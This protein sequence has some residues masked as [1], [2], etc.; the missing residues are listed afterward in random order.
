[1]T[2]IVVL[3]VALLLALPL[4][5]FGA[6]GDP[7]VGRWTPLG[8]WGATIF[9]LA[10]DPADPDRFY[11]GTPRGLFVSTDQMA[12]WHLLGSLPGRPTVGAIFVDPS[13]P[14]RI[15]AAVNATLLGSTDRGATWTSSSIDQPI[16]SLLPEVNCLVGDPTHPA[17]L[18]ACSG[19][20]F[21]QGILKSTDGGS[22]FSTVSPD[23]D[24]ANVAAIVVDPASPSTLYAAVPGNREPAL[25][26]PIGVVKSLDGGATWQARNAGLPGTAV[27][28]VVR[29]PQ[30]GALYA[31]LSSG[32]VF[33]SLDGAA[34][35]AALPVA[36]PPAS[37]LAAAPDG[38]LYLGGARGIFRSANGGATWTATPERAAAT[39]L[40]VGLGGP[41]AAAVYA[42][43]SGG[44][45]RSADSGRTWP[46]SKTGLTELAS[47]PL[48]VD[49]QTSELWITADHTYRSPGGGSAFHRLG[50]DVRS[51]AIDPTDSTRLYGILP[52]GRLVRSLD[53]G[54][55]WD[56]LP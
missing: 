10:A 17:I 14:A 7:P 42:A 30:T 56:V 34:G 22:H 16:P 54:A 32:K 29:A 43:G 41:A 12:T 9:S 26:G 51:L 47:D 28:E 20:T 55:S 44:V 2:K 39:L 48:A 38:A 24:S 3:G 23:L 8:P 5:A 53:R 52:S 37:S 19:I 15:V 13:D 1:M 25:P 11:A 18:Y 40:G 49:P 36:T 27:Q 31:V 35:W 6:P 4:G 46:L 45:L 21:G 50:R 33:Q